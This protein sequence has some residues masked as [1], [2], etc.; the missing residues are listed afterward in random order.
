MDLLNLFTLFTGGIVAGMI[1]VLAGGAGFM[2]FPLLIAAGL[3]EMEANAANFVALLPA[4]IAGTAVYRKEIA[5]VRQHLLTR[6]VLAAVGG[7]LGS[8]LF[9]WLG[10]AS[11]HTA[12]PWLLLFATLSFG[13]GPMI[14]ARLQSMQGFDA[15][16]WLWLSFL[17]EFIVYVYGGYFGLGMGIILLAIHS[18]FSHM[19]IHHAN[20][21]RNVTISL[22]TLIGIVIFAGTGLVR[23]GPSLAMMA[24]AIVGGYG[25]AKIAR[26]LPHH[27]VRNVILGWSIALTAYSIWR[28]H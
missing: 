14:R 1:N 25:M 12:I 7:T 20:A 24:G 9:V 13:L 15:A 18:I 23:W 26:G 5:E 16:R 4:N 27:V 2:T 22:M 21:L 19:S 10:E 6:L 3:S 28:Y 17:L 8:V 11:F